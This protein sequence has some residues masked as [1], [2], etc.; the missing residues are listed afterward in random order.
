MLAFTDKMLTLPKILFDSTWWMVYIG[1]L[2]NISI[3]FINKMTELVRKA[4]DLIDFM[5]F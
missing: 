5:I 3:V 2:M 1:H 4:F